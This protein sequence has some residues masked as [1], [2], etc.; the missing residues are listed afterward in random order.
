MQ[1]DLKIEEFFFLCES[2]NQEI[3]NMYSLNSIVFQEKDHNNNCTL[4]LK[5]VIKDKKNIVIGC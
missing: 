5:V 1:E 2:A 3:R 4:M